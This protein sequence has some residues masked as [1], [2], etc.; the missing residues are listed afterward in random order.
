MHYITDYH[1]HTTFSDGK[2]APED[3]IAPA[4]AKGISEIGFSEHLALF[5]D[6]QDWVL[7][8]ENVDTYLENIENLKNTTEKL[9]I[10]K[11]LEVDYLEG[12]ENEIG[13]FLDGLDLDYRIGSV[14]YLGEKTVDEGPDFYTGKSFD[15]LFESYFEMVGNAVESGLFDI[16]GHPDLIRIFGYKP[17][18]DPA[19]YYRKLAKRMKKNDVAFE[20]NTNGRNRPMADFYPDRRFLHFFSEE[21][22][23]V[24]VNSDA[25]MPSRVGQYFDEAYR[26]IKDV[27]FTSVVTF[28][29]RER[30]F[31][32]I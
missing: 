29:G 1:I 17:S 6:N 24:C 9:I 30:K 12:K 28:N 10:R 2:A 25:H 23:P 5:K 15:R 3:Y 32:A 20:I 19:P 7:K 31:T 16:I 11:G 26:L 27:G 4:I 21:K 8:P 18:F 22:V 14:H 13:I